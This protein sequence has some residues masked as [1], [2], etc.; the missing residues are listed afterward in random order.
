[1]ARNTGIQDRSVVVVFSV[2][3]IIITVVL[4]ILLSW[5]VWVSNVM[6]QQSQALEW[7][8]LAK[9]Y[10]R[11]AWVP[12]ADGT[13][14]IVAPTVRWYFYFDLA[15]EG[16]YSFHSEPLVV[17]LNGDGTLEVIAVDS[18]GRLTILRGSD[19]TR[20][21]YY[22]QKEY[23]LAAHTVPTAADLDGDG[24][25]ELVAGT[26]EG[27]VV[28]F[29]IDTTNWGISILWYSGKLVEII[30]TSPIVMDVDGDGSL[31]VL[32]NT[33]LG[34]FCL[35]GLTGKVKWFKFIRGFVTASSLAVLG[36]ING[37]GTQD[38]VY[39]DFYGQVHA[40]DGG[41]GKILWTTDLWI[42]YNLRDYG[43][44][45]HTVA[46]GDIDGDGLNEVLVPL[47]RE[48]FT[49]DAT[50]GGWYKSG[51]KGVIAIIDAIT[52]N[53][54]DTITYTDPNAPQNSGPAPWFS[55]PAL[56]LADT[57]GDN[58]LEIYIG[59]L[60]GYIYMF[61][62]S[63]GAYREIWRVQVD[64]ISNWWLNNN[65]D[66][67]YTGSS[68]IVLDADGDGNY[69]V[70]VISTYSIYSGTTYQDF[71]YKVYSIDA[72]SGTIE[73]SLLLDYSNYL[74][75]GW[76]DERDARFAWPSISA[77]D[78]DGDGSLELLVT[79]YSVVFCIDG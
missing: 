64:P 31:E 70:A 55:Q 72:L 26:R 38:T 52:G 34:V 65:V 79:G 9:D 58:I 21:A 11:T 33:N 30:N 12:I 19:G 7:P 45:I 28:A 47:A 71:N 35:D 49:Q 16:W 40:L 69:E 15:T 8:L 46:V 39:A 18:A 63:N 66:A 44:N 1:M 50:S 37:N 10:H 32:V 6:G 3:T 48:T 51:V 13:G 53:L 2:G 67:P 75:G 73:W 22:A 57:D 59:G 25:P 41:S 17:D 43:F 5:D 42:H 24:H 56:A 78:V 62:Y 77:G 4:A 61:D 74:T 68:L 29:D 54:E 23:L 27:G 60:D 14:A 20:L 76:G 36:D